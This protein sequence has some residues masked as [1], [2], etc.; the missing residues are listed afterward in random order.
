MNSRSSS[1]ILFLGALT[2][3]LFC[4]DFGSFDGLQSISIAKITLDVKRHRGSVSV[5]GGT[6][7]TKPS[8]HPVV[9]GTGDFMFVQGIVTSSPFDLRGLTV[10][11][12]IEF[13]LYWPPYVMKT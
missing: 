6:H 2:L 1:R 11:Y 4:G 12:K 8:E 10:T 13:D 3:G 9:G 7:N 5:V